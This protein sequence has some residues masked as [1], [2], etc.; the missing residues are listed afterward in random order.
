MDKSLMMV[1][2]AQIISTVA[3]IYT[4]KTEISWIKKTLDTHEQDIR[5]IKAAR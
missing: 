5:L 2:L 3:I 4:N 1:M